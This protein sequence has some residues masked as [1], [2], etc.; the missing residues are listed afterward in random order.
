VIRRVCADNLLQHVIEFIHH[1]T[2]PH[3]PLLRVLKLVAKE[4]LDGDLV[5]VGQLLPRDDYVVQPVG[6]ITDPSIPE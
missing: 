4:S 5:A 2:A 3:L 1:R 6:A